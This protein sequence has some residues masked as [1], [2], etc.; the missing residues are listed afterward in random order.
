MSNVVR[1]RLIADGTVLALVASRIYMIQLEQNC[2]L[3]AISTVPL[4]ETPQNAIGGEN[5]LKNESWQVDCWDNSYTDVETLADAVE[6]AMAAAGT[7]F[8][9]V[10]TDRSVLFEN[11]TGL[12]RISIDYSLWI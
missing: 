10:R 3:P 7:D 9:A 2:T 6:S 12:Y 11:Q 1:A 8:D 5:A 4:G